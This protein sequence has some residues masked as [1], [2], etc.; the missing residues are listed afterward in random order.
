MS[1]RGRG[2]RCSV[3]VGKLWE[4]CVKTVCCSERH[5][6]DAERL[7]CK[8]AL[9]CDVCS[10]VHGPIHAGRVVAA[11]LQLGGGVVAHMHRGS[12]GGEWGQWM[13][14]G[15]CGCG[16]D[17]DDDDDRGRYCGDDDDDDMNNNTQHQSSRS[18]NNTTNTSH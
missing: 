7:D 13:D 6:L 9:A 10:H 18:N 16:C 17:G 8:V 4:N 14:E 3:A 12:G 11:Q 5:A 15:D 2:E 1:G